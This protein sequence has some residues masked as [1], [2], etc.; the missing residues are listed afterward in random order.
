MSA[1]SFFLDTNVIVYAND[2]SQTQ[3]QK[4]AVQLITRGM[5]SGRGVISSQV[6]G[7]FWVTVTQKIKVPLARETALQEIEAFRTM[8]IVGVEYEAV[9]IGISLQNRFTISYW[10]ALILAAAGIGGCKTVYSEDL[11]DGQE[12]DKITVINPFGEV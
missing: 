4:I 2:S 7:E 3:K 6:L 1:D 5:R 11:N 12:Y 8:R 10:D 9:R